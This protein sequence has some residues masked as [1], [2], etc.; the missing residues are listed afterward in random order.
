MWTVRT[1]H[2]HPISIIVLYVVKHLLLSSLLGSQED[3]FGSG[4]AWQWSYYANRLRGAA[5]LAPEHDVAFG[6]YIVGR[7]A[8]PTGLAQKMLAL[9]GNG[10]KALR[11]YTFGPECEWSN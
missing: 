3:W 11:I 8:A 9:V 4:D 1:G 10:A 7:D 2:D 5:E 6:G